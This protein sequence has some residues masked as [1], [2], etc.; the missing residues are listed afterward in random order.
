MTPKVLRTV[1]D[2]FN[3]F[4]SGRKLQQN[5]RDYV[6]Q[7]VQGMI[8]SPETQE[9]LR[10]GEHYGYY[11]HQ[12]RQNAKKLNIGETEIINIQ[13]KPIVVQNV[14]SNVTREI[15]CDDNGIV[16]HTQEILGT[17]TGIIVN[18][19][20]DAA[21]GWSWATGGSQNLLTKQ[22]IARSFHGFDYVLQPNYISLNKTAMMTESVSNIESMLLESIVAGGIDTD[23]AKDAINYLTIN[24]MNHSRLAE[25]EQHNMMLESIINSQYAQTEDLEILKAQIKERDRMMLEAIES[26]PVFVSDEQRSALRMRNNDDKQAVKLLFESLNSSKFKSLPINNQSVTIKKR[27]SIDSDNNFMTLNRNVKFN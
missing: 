23:A 9:G 10:L 8:N 16:T 18:G 2:S 22:A 6:I 20:Y 21:G 11:G 15:S 13:G 12:S 1:E 26:L 27:P 4:N 14:P 17:P 5:G 19:M 7:S 24:E 25:L 3:L